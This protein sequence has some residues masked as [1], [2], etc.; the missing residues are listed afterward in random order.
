MALVV[1][2]VMVPPPLTDHVTPELFLSFATV[3]E[4]LTVSVASTMAVEG[5]TDTAGLAEDPPQPDKRRMETKARRATETALF[6]YTRSSRDGSKFAREAQMP[7]EAC[8]AGETVGKSLAARALPRLGARLLAY[9]VR[10]GA[11]LLGP[12]E[13]TRR[14]QMSLGLGYHGRM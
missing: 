12:R 9:V 3:A 11:Q 5:L 13:D 2:L 6:E 8:G 1:E 10:R 14:T 7:S 4:R